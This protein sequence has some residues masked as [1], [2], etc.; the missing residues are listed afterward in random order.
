[1]AAPAWD[2]LQQKQGVTTTSMSAR[3]TC[4][5]QGTAVTD[6][7][8]ASFEVHLTPGQNDSYLFLVAVDPPPWEMTIGV[9]F[10]TVKTPMEKQT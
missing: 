5:G 3:P 10:P 1:M 2:L 8:S 9:R 6:I 7:L 4:S